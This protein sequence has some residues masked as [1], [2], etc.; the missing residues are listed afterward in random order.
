MLS[1][2]RKEEEKELSFACRCCRVDARTGSCGDG[3][4]RLGGPGPGNLVARRMVA[5]GKVPGLGFQRRSFFSSPLRPLE[6][7]KLKSVCVGRSKARGTS[8]R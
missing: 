7:I 8:R 2:R 3:E 4:A 5:A 1:K 6:P